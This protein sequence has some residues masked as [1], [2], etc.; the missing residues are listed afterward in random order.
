MVSSHVPKKHPKKKISEGNSQ[1][2]IPIRISVRQEH[3]PA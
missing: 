1:G 3:V 2:K